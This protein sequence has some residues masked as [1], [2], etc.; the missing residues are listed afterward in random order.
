MMLAALFTGVLG[1]NCTRQLSAAAAA[2]AAARGRREDTLPRHKHILDQ[3]ATPQRHLVK[4]GSCE[5]QNE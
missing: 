1:V 5:Q 3:A 4:S 2:A